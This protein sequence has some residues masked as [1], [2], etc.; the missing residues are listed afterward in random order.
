MTI[1]QSNQLQEL[2]DKIAN[3]DKA[4]C[5]YIE[6][7]TTSNYTH[8]SWGGRYTPSFKLGINANGYTEITLSII[9]ETSSSNYIASHANNPILEAVS[10][11]IIDDQTIYVEDTT[12][13]IEI[14]ITYG[15]SDVVSSSGA[16]FIKTLKI[17]SFA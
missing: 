3:R 8:N 7:F 4:I 9:H 16:T 11:C 2:Y 6:Y 10:N 1:E 14:N 12:K 13:S 17:S 5:P 15:I